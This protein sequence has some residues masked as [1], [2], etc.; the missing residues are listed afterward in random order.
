MGAQ[1][2][3]FTPCLP[4]HWQQAELTLTRAGRT[5][6]FV[7]ARIAP[8]VALSQAAAGS[9]VVLLPGDALPWTTLATH[10]RFIVPLD[11]PSLSAAP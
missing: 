5:M 10:T 9:A 8:L 2:L 3:S 7:L 1:E 11:S 6:H 4:S